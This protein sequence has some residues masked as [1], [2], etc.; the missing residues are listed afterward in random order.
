MDLKLLKIPYLAEIKTHMKQM[1][2]LLIGCCALFFVNSCR[3]EEANIF[4]EKHLFAT[5]NKNSLVYSKDQYIYKDLSSDSTGSLYKFNK[6]GGLIFYC[7]LNKNF[8]G[9][10]EYFDSFGKRIKTEG[11]PFVQLRTSTNKDSSYTLSFL[12]S[13]FRKSNYEIT[14]YSS[15]NDTFFNTLSKVK[16]YSNV[17]GFDLIIRSNKVAL[18]TQL[19]NN[20]VYFDSI[21]NSLHSFADTILVKDV[22]K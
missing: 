18:K 8:Y 6:K 1:I 11:T 14:T 10:S 9:Y 19:I 17:G 21:S 5:V 16:A 12:Y 22:L 15:F 13:T 7:F 3:R 2:K 20:V 4:T